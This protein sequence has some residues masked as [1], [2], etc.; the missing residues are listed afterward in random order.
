MKQFYCLFV[1]ALMLISACKKSDTTKEPCNPPSLTTSL[2]DKKVNVSV[3][4]NTPQNGY[5][6]EYGAD[7]F[8]PGS[9]TTSNFGGTSTDFTVSAY[10]KYNIY[11]RKKCS[12]GTTSAWSS[13]YT[14]NVDGS[15]A[16]CSVP[17]RLDVVGSN[18]KPKFEWYD[19]T[20]NFYD[21]EY[22]PTGFTIG[23]GTRIR[24]NDDYTYDA[25]MQ[26]GVTYD[27]YV[28][29]NCGGS[30]FSTWAGPHSY[31]AVENVNI[32]VA[33][34]QPTNLYAY[35]VSSTEI[36]YTATGNGSISYEVS[37]STSNSSISNN[38]L[39]VSSP[40]GSVYNTGGYSGTRYFWIRG[41]CFNN[42]FTPWSVSQVQ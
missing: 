13:K 16:G 20:G 42:S 39:S 8:A 24:T 2:E 33:C 14:V 22:G 26:Q 10:G 5:D 4:D 31:Y 38:I 40:N 29:S 34:T 6:I 3:Q 30:S 19:Y 32:A 25:I 17:E 7:G 21:V 37:I 28:R 41:K 9:G 15:S 35:K 11:I 1:S 23:N 27:F 36:N 18:S 12:D